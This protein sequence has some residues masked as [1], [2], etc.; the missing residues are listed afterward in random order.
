MRIKIFAVISYNFDIDKMSELIYYNMQKNFQVIVLDLTQIYI[1]KKYP[2]ISRESIKSS[3][4][5]I[6]KFYT[7]NSIDYYVKINEGIFFLYLSARIFEISALRIFKSKICVSFDYT[8]INSSSENNNRKINIISIY[9]KIIYIIYKIFKYLL[10]PQMII[11]T[12]EGSTRSKDSNSIIDIHPKLFNSSVV[13]LNQENKVINNRIIIIF[14]NFTFED[15]DFIN[16][17]EE[18]PDFE[19]YFNSFSK[20]VDE[21]INNLLTPIIYFHPKTKRNMIPN[22]ARNLEHYFGVPTDAILNSKLIIGHFSTVLLAA[23]QLGKPI[24]ILNSVVFS[25]SRW[26]QGQ[27]NAF[28][29]KLGVQPIMLENYEEIINT[30]NYYTD[31]NYNSNVD[32]SNEAFHNLTNKIKNIYYIKN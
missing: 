24:L 18:S 16:C 30:C 1:N 22:W 9:S 14:Q 5:E 2:G 10:G 7:I 12:I 26:L 6:I 19:I 28:S 11:S 31:I 23:G 21:L 17:G 25:D 15:Y 32:L 29:Q 20:L 3:K 27:I 13:E 4:F 8:L